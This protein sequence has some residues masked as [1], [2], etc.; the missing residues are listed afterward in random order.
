MALLGPNLSPSLSLCPDGQTS[1]E[2]FLIDLLSSTNPVDNQIYD[3]IPLV[4]NHSFVLSEFTPFLY[5]WPTIRHFCF[6]ILHVNKYFFI[7]CAL[8]RSCGPVRYVQGPSPGFFPS[9]FGTEVVLCYGERFMS[10]VDVPFEVATFH[11]KADA[12]RVTSVDLDRERATHAFRLARLNGTYSV[13]TARCLGAMRRQNATVRYVVPAII[14]SEVVISIPEYVQPPQVC[15]PLSAFLNSFGRFDSAVLRLPLRRFD[16]GYFP[17]CHFP[18][19]P[20]PHRPLQCGCPTGLLS[21]SAPE[22]NIYAG[23]SPKGIVSRCFSECTFDLD[24]FRYSTHV[25]NVYQGFVQILS[26][27]LQDVLGEF[28]DLS[29][30]IERGLWRVFGGAFLS[31]LSRLAFRFFTLLNS[32]HLFEPLFSY[33]ILFFYFDDHSRAIILSLIFHLISR[34]WFI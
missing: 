6:Q 23:V 13:I 7:G 9:L 8:P 26:M 30:I 22:A 19:R 34:Y 20:V 12:H 27:L 33:L 15:L 17:P 3:S 28:F 10:T 25:K 5:Q 16:L 31:L 29:D 14:G 2:P 11:L 21:F 32:Y 1:C 4:F 24:D 18:C